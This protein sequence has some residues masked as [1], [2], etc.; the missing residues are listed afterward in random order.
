[1]SLAF[2]QTPQASSVTQTFEN[3]AFTSS[4]Q[5]TYRKSCAAILAFGRN[6][7]IGYTTPKAY[8]PY[9]EFQKLSAFYG[10]RTRFRNALKV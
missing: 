7:L 6:Y 5:R 3:G 8:L 10:V 4:G 1:M 9:L 2:S